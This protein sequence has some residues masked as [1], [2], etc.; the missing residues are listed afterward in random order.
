MRPGDGSDPMAI[1]ASIP[2]TSVA[3][4]AS[5]VPGVAHR[6]VPAIKTLAVY[7]IIVVPGTADRV[8]L[9]AANP[10]LQVVAASTCSVHEA[11]KNSFAADVRRHKTLARLDTAACAMRYARVAPVARIPSMPPFDASAVAK[12]LI[13]FGHRTALRGGNPYRSRSCYRS[14]ESLLALAA[15]LQDI[16]RQAPLREIPGV[17]KAIADIITKLHETGT[18][19]ALERMRKEIPAGVLELLNIPGLR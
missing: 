11:E 17:G 5:W 3:R 13:E 8:G 19:P 6:I 16:V 18:H 15:P 14:S 4:A 7:L 10:R 9:P 12:L 2:N 1:S